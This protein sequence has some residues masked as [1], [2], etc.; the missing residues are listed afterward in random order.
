MDN[1][2]WPTFLSDPRKVLDLYDQPPALDRCDLFYVHI[3]ERD[4]SITFGFDTSEL[5]AHPRQ[6]WKEKP[7]NSIRFFISF[8]GT[9]Q[10]HVNGWESPGQ[11]NVGISRDSEDELRVQVASD[12]SSL[13]FRAK[14]ASV[15]HSTAQLTASDSYP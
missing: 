11:K 7:F 12:G 14:S 15:T 4:T 13:S 2:T 8:T 9:S 3:D 5:P 6:K 1:A 10:L